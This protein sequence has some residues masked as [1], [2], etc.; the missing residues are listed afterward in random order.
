MQA[1]Q[2]RRAD[3]VIALRLGGADP[4]LRHVAD[5]SRS[6]PFDGMSPLEYA[7][8]LKQK[9]LIPLLESTLEELKILATP[10]PRTAAEVPALWKRIEKHANKVDKSIKKSLNRAASAQDVEAI[11]KTCGISLPAD[12]LAS[13]AIHD[14]Q[15]PGAEESLVPEDW[16][17]GPYELLPA[18]T[19]VREWNMWKSLV[20]AGEFRNQTSTPDDG[21]RDAWWHP[22]WIP[23]AGNGGGDFLCL[24]LAPAD[25][26]RVGQVIEM[27][28]D[29]PAR[30]FVAVTFADFLR[31]LADR[32]ENLAAQ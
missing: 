28:H 23:I 14:G 20:D 15:K 24:D 25:K 29:S 10:A 7:K 6:Q 19:I 12:F 16:F 3:A 4:N 5:A 18:E 2:N 26:G 31:E 21:I 22:R 8:A 30:R 11:E 9:K 32:L 13:C 27:R 1:V 17:D